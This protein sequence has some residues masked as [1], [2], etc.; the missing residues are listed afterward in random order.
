MKSV[1]LENFTEAYSLTNEKKYDISNN[2]QKHLLFKQFVA[3][4]CDGCSI[5]PLTDCI[6]NPICI[7]QYFNSSDERVY[8]DL[9]ASYG[10]TKEMEKLERN[11]S[12]LTLK[13][14]LKNVVAKKHRLRIRGH[15]I[16]EYLYIL[17]KDGLTLQHKTY[18][19]PSTDNDFE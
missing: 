2:T 7:I 18:S 11:I 15:T 1:T 13:I 16:G 9:R 5:A 19:I 12:K 17:A 10:C 4:S 6:N 14:K 3:W 8:L